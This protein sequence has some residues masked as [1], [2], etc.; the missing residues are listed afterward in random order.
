MIMKAKLAALVTFVLS[1]FTLVACS[2]GVDETGEEYGS[3]RLAQQACTL[4]PPV[5]TEVREENPGPVA[6]GITKIYHVQVRN[7]NSTG[8][9]PASLTF[10]P[11]SFMFFSIVVQ[12]QTI[13]G[14]AS[15][16]VANFRVAVTSD[17]SLPE[18]VTDIGFTIVANNPAGGATTARG[19]LRYEIDLDNPV[20]CNRQVPQAEVAIVSPSPVPPGGTINYRVTVRNVDNR[21]CGPDTFF[22]GTQNPRFF[23]ITITPLQLTIP[24]G[25]SGTF[26]I[27][28]TSVAGSP[29]GPGVHNLTIFIFGQRHQ[30]NLVG[31]GTLRYEVR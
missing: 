26:D 29:I 24:A 4:A 21:E 18:G 10:I 25:S 3:V 7:A 2:A 12:P 20:G 15:G 14:V 28:V 23:T 16:T 9:A 27:S 30:G 31:Q 11:D 8:C 6:P 1:L 17:Q 19:S 5:I 22:I 13:S